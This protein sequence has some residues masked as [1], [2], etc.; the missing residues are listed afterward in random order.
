VPRRESKC[1][2]AQDAENNSSLAMRSGVA[3]GAKRNQV[4]FRIIAGVAAKLLVVN[5]KI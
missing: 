4:L 5:L 2:N 1:S 3:S